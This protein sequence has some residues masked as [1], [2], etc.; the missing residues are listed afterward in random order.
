MEQFL[1]V[2]I[3]TLVKLISLTE[4]ELPMN[5]QDLPVK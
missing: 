5:I 3:L 4:I 1:Q 2:T